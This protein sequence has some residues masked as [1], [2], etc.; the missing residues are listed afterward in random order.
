MIR[1]RIT[2]IIAGIISCILVSVFMCRIAHILIDTQK[3]TNDYYTP[4]YMVSDEMN[5]IYYKLWA[6]GNMWLRNLDEKGDFKGSEALKNQTVSA[7]QELGC[8]DSAGNIA[9]D[10]INNDYDFFVSYG[11]NSFSNTTKKYDDFDED[12]SLLRKNDN[13]HYS[14]FS[15]VIHTVNDFNMY[16]TNYGMHYYYLCGKGIAL[17]DFDTNGLP[18]YMDELGATLYYKTDGSTPLPDEYYYDNY[19]ENNYDYTDDDYQIFDEIY[20]EDGNEI[21]KTNVSCEI[22]LYDKYNN[23]VS[24]ESVIYDEYGEVVGRERDVQNPENIAVTRE[25]VVYDEFGDVISRRKIPIEDDFDDGVYIRQN[26]EFIKVEQEDFK[27]VQLK[28]MSLVIAVQP[29]SEIVSS[30]ET[31]YNNMEEV[32]KNTFRT[33]M[34]NL[35]MLIVAGIL[36]LFVL[37]TGG[38]STKEKKFVMTSADR[39]FAELFVGL[40]FLVVVAVMIFADSCDFYDFYRL[41]CELY[42]EQ[43][44]YAICGAVFFALFGIVVLSLNTLVVRI[45]CHKFCKSTF[46]YAF[47]VTVWGWIKKIRSFTAEKFISYDMVRND[48]FTRRF[49]IRTVLFSIA[50]AFFTVVCLDFGAW[51]PWMF[52]SV[53]LLAGYITLSLFDLNAMNRISRHITAINKG[54]YTPHTENKYSSAYCITQKLN[55]ISAGIQS[56]VDNQVKSERMKIELVTNVSHDLKTPL[57]SI[58]SYIDLLSTEELSPVARDYVNIIDNKSQRL[59]SMVEDLFDLA[60]ATSRTDID[61]E[62]ID[63][64]ILANQVLADLSDKIESTGKQI[65]IDIQPVSAP[66]IAEGKKMYRVFQNVIDNALKYSLDGT[67]IYFNLRA[68]FGYC[69]LTVKNIA[70]Y[71]MDFTPDEIMER[72]TRGDKSRNTE[73]NGLGLSI[74]KSFTEACGGM[75]GVDIDGDVFTAEVKLPINHGNIDGNS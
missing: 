23:V 26:G 39:I 44:F 38:Y 49:I 13:I 70:S 4:A 19:I 53:I 72:F 42:S 50:E 16:D 20:D 10:D 73:G 24:R 35:P 45:K 37:I 22:T 5:S 17:Y 30:I 40:V 63:A 21:D 9:L 3:K 6:V 68:E 36:L 41:I 48:K 54:D 55:N 34:N 52:L 1:N 27:T 47:A 18:S 25:I 65:K 67:R 28:E 15:G 8:M 74:A 69:V 64:V 58:I 12:Y 56:A 29:S 59:K 14:N 43:M 11:N 71:E 2:R 31:Y 61:V 57:T 33:L 66:V 51:L 75:F 62:R 60:K 32:S 7:L 46:V